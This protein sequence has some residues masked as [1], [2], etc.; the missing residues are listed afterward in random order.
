MKR[1]REED[2][3]NY[4]LKREREI[5]NNKWEDEKKSREK[6]LA[7]SEAEIKKK[8]DDIK[9]NE[10]YVKDLEKQVVGISDLLLKEYEK[11]KKDV[12]NILNK[13]HK[14]EIDLLS[15]DFQ[16]KID[17][18]SDKIESLKLEIKQ[19][20]DLN[21]SLQESLDKAYAQIK[22][23]ATKTVEATGG[24]KIIGNNHNEQRLV[25]NLFSCVIET[26]NL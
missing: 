26:E 19:V 9:A 16:N 21:T 23:M 2:E 7:D 15:K 24:V 11:G 25:F 6:K 12:S 14:Y 18:Q 22:E 10:Q 8:L 5:S 13:E 1:D 3:Y 17:R 20:L 4:N